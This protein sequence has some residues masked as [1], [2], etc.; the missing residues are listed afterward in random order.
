MQGAPTT[1]Q[2]IRGGD[3]SAGWIVLVNGYGIDAVARTVDELG[4][5]APGAIARVYKLA[6]TLGGV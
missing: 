5:A 6:Y 1:E 3:K 2:K 4:G